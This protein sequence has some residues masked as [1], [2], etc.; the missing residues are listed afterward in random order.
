MNKDEENKSSAFAKRLTKGRVAETL[1][2]MMFNDHT[3]YDLLPFGY[4]YTN[5]ELIRY[6]KKLRKQKNSTWGKVAGTPDFILLPQDRKEVYV[7]EVKFLSNIQGNY[8][9]L[10]AKARKMVEYWDEVYFFVATPG[11]FYFDEGVNFATKSL[12]NISELTSKFI[13]KRI[14]NKYLLT[15]KEL[16]QIGLSKFETHKNFATFNLICQHC[17]FWI[18]YDAEII[19]PKCKKRAVE[20]P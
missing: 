6:T 2:W 20:F 15:L 3:Q 16:L 8:K 17:S 4:E 5:P 11:K 1:F 12:D 7:V 18:D 13:P 9:S 10:S 14:Q 19:C